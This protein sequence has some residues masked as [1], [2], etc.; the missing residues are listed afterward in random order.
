[1]KDGEM[2]R[3]RS[4]I[5]RAARFIITW[6]QC[7]ALLPPSQCAFH[8]SNADGE[9][10]Y[11][12]V[13]KGGRPSLHFQDVEEGQL[14]MLRAAQYVES[15]CLSLRSKT[16][17]AWMRAIEFRVPENLPARVGLSRGRRILWLTLVLRLIAETK[18][19]RGV[20]SVAQRSP[21]YC[22]HNIGTN[23]S[24]LFPSHRSDSCQPYSLP[25]GKRKS[26][27]S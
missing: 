9:R 21:R 19:A 17:L 1:M 16:H 14:N 4:N 8:G 3:D 26:V 15:S 5:R 13:S 18:A 20:S 7:V 27:N 23:F 12:C 6:L 11:H 24:N 2:K 10:L 25:I 22:V